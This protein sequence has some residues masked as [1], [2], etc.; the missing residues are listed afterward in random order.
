MN[1]DLAEYY[2]KVAL[3]GRSGQGAG[4]LHRLDRYEYPFQRAFRLSRSFRLLYVLVA[5]GH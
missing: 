1:G 5:V 4:R 2:H 3:F